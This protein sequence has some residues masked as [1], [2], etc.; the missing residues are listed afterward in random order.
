MISPITIAGRKIGSDF[1]PYLIAE[2]SANH[3]GS[4][5]RA[6]KSIQVAKESGADAIKLQ[7]YTPDTM[8]IDSDRPEFQITSGLW[9]G[10]NLYNLYQWAHTPFEWHKELFDFASEIDLTLFST[11]FDET[12]VD[13]LEEL[14]APAYK[15][16]SFEIVDLPLIK[17]VAQ[18]KKPLI[19]STG[20]ASLLEIEEAILVAQD[21]GC[22]QIAILHCTSSYPAHATDLNLFNIPELMK[23]F[24]CVVGFSDHSLGIEAATAS[25]ALGARIIEKH[26]SIDPSQEGPD[27]AFS[28]S[29]HELTELTNAL[30]NSWTS[31]GSSNFQRPDSESQSKEHRRSIYFIRNLKAGQIVTAKD[32]KRIRPGLGMPPKYWDEIIG[33]T[34]KFDVEAGTP[35]EWRFFT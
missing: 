2:L 12:A 17:Y 34:L 3:N 7:T 10:F 31:L 11:P 4:I 9:S 6:L 29:R 24:N 30:I 19:I 32:I 16:A 35:A 27:S 8:T 25:V 18:T 13:L 23:K 21:A 26:F 28:S 15:I 14:N 20:M 1:P 22:D 33:K 5:D